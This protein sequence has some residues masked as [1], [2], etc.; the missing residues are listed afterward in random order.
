MQTVMGVVAVINDLHKGRD[1]G[2][3]WSVVIDV[4][5]ILMVLV[6]V[7]GI[8]LIFYLKRRRFSGIVTAVVGTILVALVFVLWVP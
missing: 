4:T 7:T 5:A 8:V 2:F 1:S 6:S 3:A